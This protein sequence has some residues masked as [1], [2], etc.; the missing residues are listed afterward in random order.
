MEHLLADFHRE[1]DYRSAKKPGFP[2][3]KPGFLTSI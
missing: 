2:R 1:L 3:G